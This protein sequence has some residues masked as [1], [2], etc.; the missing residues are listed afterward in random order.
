MTQTL[1]RF[2][3]LKDIHDTLKW[4]SDNLEHLNSPW[5]PIFR[6]PHSTPILY[7]PPL[8]CFHMLSSFRC[9]FFFLRKTCKTARSNP[10]ENRERRQS[11]E[12]CE[13]G[14]TS[15]T[16]EVSLLVM[17][18]C[19]STCPRTQQTALMII[20]TSYICDYISPESTYY[21]L[22]ACHTLNCFD[23]HLIYTKMSFFIP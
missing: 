5:V 8:F 4:Q 18:C 17:R 12:Y 11:R 10:A 13:E 16:P 22:N 23:P 1:P 15:G 19:S 2:S 9:F 7:H 21:Q 20:G 6:A 3:I 14:L